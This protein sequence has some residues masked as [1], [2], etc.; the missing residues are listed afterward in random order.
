PLSSTSTAR[1]LPPHLGQGVVYLPSRAFVTYAMPAWRRNSWA[2][3]R[4]M[5]APR[6][7]DRSWCW[8]IAVIGR[9]ALAAAASAMA[10]APSRPRSRPPHARSAG[11]VNYANAEFAKVER[12]QQIGQQ[13]VEHFSLLIVEAATKAC[14]GEA[15]YAKKSPAY[16]LGVST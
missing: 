11:G 14:A 5:V 7:R 10:P 13:R 9:G 6:K 4:L 2:E 1:F 15:V 3:G 16:A 8:A 12:R